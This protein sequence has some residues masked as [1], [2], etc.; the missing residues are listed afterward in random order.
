MSFSKRATSTRSCPISVARSEAVLV[1]ATV[2]V[3]VGG[4]GGGAETSIILS[5]ISASFSRVVE[6][7]V[8][9]NTIRTLGGKHCKNSSCRNE[10]SIRPEWF[11]SSCCILR[12]SW[13]GFRSPNS[14]P[15]KSCWSFRCSEA[16]VR[17]VSCSLRAVYGLSAGGLSKRSLTSAA[18]SGD[19]EDTTWSNLERSDVMRR[20][21]N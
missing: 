4:A 9:A 18:N 12:R 7:G 6:A 8:E 21:A 16:V 10:L 17:L 15:V 1:A 14:S 2:S 3:D 11:P 19:S 5:A 20:H 13:V